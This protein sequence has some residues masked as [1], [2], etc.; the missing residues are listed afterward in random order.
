MTLKFELKSGEKLSVFFNDF[1]KDES[2]N[3]YG[4]VSWNKSKD[5]KHYKEAYAYVNK[6]DS[7]RMYFKY[8]DEIVYIDDFLAMTPDELL[9]EM[10]KNKNLRAEELVYTLMKH[11]ID[12]LIVK[13]PKKP[14]TGFNIGGMFYGFESSSNDDDKSKW[15]RVDYK[16]QEI[17]GFPLHRNYKIRLVPLK[18]EHIGVYASDTYYISD[19]IHLLIGCTDDYEI[20]VNN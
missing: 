6:D 17:D 7:G 1:I 18:D 12:S 9:Q 3:Q 20:R 15:N 13:R 10:R 5:K 19:L 16:F 4:V 14:M 11:G 2:K 8:N